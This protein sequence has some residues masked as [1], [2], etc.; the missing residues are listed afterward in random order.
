MVGEVIKDTP[1]IPPLTKH[2]PTPNFRRIWGETLWPE[3]DNAA[4]FTSAL[5]NNTAIISSDGSVSGG[6]GTT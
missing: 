6:H 1:L 2:L 4:L 3:A 5:K